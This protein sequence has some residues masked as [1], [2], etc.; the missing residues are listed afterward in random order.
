MKNGISEKLKKK[1]KKTNFL[2]FNVGSKMFRKR[3]SSSKKEKKKK[4]RFKRSTLAANESGNNGRGKSGGVNLCKAGWAMTAGGF[5]R[6][7]EENAKEKYKKREG[8]ER[9][10]N[11]VAWVA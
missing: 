10:G 8:E 6:K 9:R 11:R 2:T 7:G 4:T 5:W 1:K 3:Q